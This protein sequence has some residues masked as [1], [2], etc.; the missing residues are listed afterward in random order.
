MDIS[1]DSS[2]IVTSSAD[3]NIKVWGLKFGDCYV[4]LFA[5]QD[6]VMGVQF[7]ADSHYFWSIGKDGVV[8][9]WDGDKF[10]CI[11]KLEG[12]HSDV[13]ALATSHKGRFVITASTDKSIRVW[14]KTDEPLFI[15]EQREREL[16]QL[17]DAPAGHDPL[18]LTVSKPTEDDGGEALDVAKTTVATLT[19]GERI[20]E[21]LDLAEVDR[22][23][24]ATAK[25]TGQPRE[26]RNALLAFHGDDY[27]AEKHVLQ[28]MEKIPSSQLSDALLILPF[29]K[30]SELVYHVQYW[31]QRRWN[32]PLASR[33]LFFILKVHH[34][35]IVA[36]QSMRDRLLSLRVDLRSALAHRKVCFVLTMPTLLTS[37]DRT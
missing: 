28:E 16:E 10:D 13:L 19:A 20:I 4:S 35:Q 21:A 33:T 15:Q 27:T 7:E 2:L 34:S 22:H 29:S 37:T 30:V 11:Q 1:H 32:I 17:Y 14:E 5:H 24:I 25:A 36:T 6:T 26:P 31:I 18:S 3:K 8:K 23:A 12:H 9:Y